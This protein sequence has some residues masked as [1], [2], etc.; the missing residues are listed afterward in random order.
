VNLLSSLPTWL[1]T[2]A[3]LPFLPAEHPWKGRRFTLRDWHDHQTM[4]CRWF[5]FYLWTLSALAVY[6]LSSV[7]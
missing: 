5:D 3:I 1:L 6:L 7:Q 2:S 4:M